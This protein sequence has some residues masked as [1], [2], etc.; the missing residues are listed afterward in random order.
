MA[1]EKEKVR[2]MEE[3]RGRLLQQ[4]ESRRFCRVH[5]GLVKLVN[6]LVLGPDGGRRGPVPA[7]AEGVPALPGAAEPAARVQTAGRSQPA[8]AGEGEPRP[9]PT[10]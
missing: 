8:G 1:L 10:R 5:N 3:E 2:L 4:V 6:V 9:D 7:A